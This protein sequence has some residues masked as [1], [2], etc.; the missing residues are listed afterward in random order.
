MRKILIIFIILFSYSSVSNAFFISGKNSCENNVYSYEI[1]PNVSFADFKVKVGPVVSFADIRIKLVGDPNQADLIF[2][3]EKLLNTSWLDDVNMKVCKK[4]YKAN[5]KIKAGPVVSFADIKV[6]VGP[7]VTSP[8]YKLYYN[9]ALFSVNE[10]AG[11]FIAIWK[12]NI[13]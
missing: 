4:S 5:R 1:G 10:A 3:D 12:F 13:K 11:L 6:R 7:N 8:D 2:V 9:S